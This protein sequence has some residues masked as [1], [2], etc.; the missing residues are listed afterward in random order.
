MA[1]VQLLDSGGRIAIQGK[2]DILAKSPAQRGDAGEKS[3]QRQY[4]ALLDPVRDRCGGGNGSA[5]GKLRRSAP[6]T[7]K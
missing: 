4:S 3:C 5:N 2:P 7:I 1:E 6:E